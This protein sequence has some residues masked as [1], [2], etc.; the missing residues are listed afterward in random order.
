MIDILQLDLPIFRTRNHEGT[1]I[2]LY[3]FDGIH[4]IGKFIGGLLWIESHVESLYV[5]LRG[6]VHDECIGCCGFDF[7]EVFAV[8]VDS[9]C[10]FPSL[11][12]VL[13]DYD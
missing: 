11:G 8:V 9:E 12:F 2:E 5:F 13:H 7:E 4:L 3:L 10:Q 6:Q 1:A